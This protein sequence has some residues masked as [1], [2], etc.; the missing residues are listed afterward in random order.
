MLLQNHT[1]NKAKNIVF[2]K[3]CNDK[4]N[5]AILN[6]KISRIFKKMYCLECMLL[7]YIQIIKYGLPKVWLKRFKS[8]LNF[9]EVRCLSYIK[10]G[11]ISN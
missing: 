5:Y 10:E 2:F 1:I 11:F 8:K 6:L 4:L 9:F 3:L 7:C